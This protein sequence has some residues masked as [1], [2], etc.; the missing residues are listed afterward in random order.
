VAFLRAK[1][2][3]AANSVHVYTSPHLVRFNERIRRAPG[4]GQIVDDETL[5]DAIRQIQSA[6]A[7]EPI[8]FF[9]VTTAVALHLYRQQPCRFLPAGSGTRRRGRCDQRRSPRRLLG[10]RHGQPRPCRVPRARTWR[11]RGGKGRHP[12]ARRPGVIGPQD[13]H[14]LAMIAL[15]A[16]AAGAPLF[17]HGSDFTPIPSAGGWSTRTRTGC[18]TCR[19]RG[20]PATTRSTMP[21]WPSRAA[22]RRDRLPPGAIEA[23]LAHAEWPARMAAAEGQVRW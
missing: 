3:A 17:A 23:G 11:D 10:H 1:L 19:C 18:S 15:E 2:E 16:K 9:E 5:I 4:R 12:E 6:N 20:W 13:E 8:T 22:A 21:A 7:D 14:A